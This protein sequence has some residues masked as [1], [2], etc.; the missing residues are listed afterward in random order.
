M[1]AVKTMTPAHEAEALRLLAIGLTGPSIAARLGVDAQAIYRLQ[2]ANG[3]RSA[4]DAGAVAYRRD[5]QATYDRLAATIADP[6]TA[7]KDLAGL[8]LAQQRTI[9]MLRTLDHDAPDAG[10]EEVARVA[11]SMRQKLARMSHAVREVPVPPVVAE[12]DDA[13]DEASG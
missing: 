11:E 9:V 1:A 2:R 10:A 4:S 7:T 13:A 5:L 6:E 12:L 8:T 3:A